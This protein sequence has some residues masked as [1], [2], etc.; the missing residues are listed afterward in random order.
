MN[1]LFPLC[2]L[3]FIGVCWHVQR[4]GAT[5]RQTL[6]LATGAAVLMAVAVLNYATSPT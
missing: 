1:V 2:M 5:H 6:W 3:L 4:G